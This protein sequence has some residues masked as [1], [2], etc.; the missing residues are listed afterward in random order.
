MIKEVYNLSSKKFSSNPKVLEEEEM[1]RFY[2]GSTLS[3]DGGRR[4]R[5]F[6]IKGKDG[7]IRGMW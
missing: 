5:V 6:D 2:D 1:G 3:V 7:G 4:R